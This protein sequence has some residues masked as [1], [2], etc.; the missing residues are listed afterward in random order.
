MVKGLDGLLRHLVDE[1]ALCGV[2]GKTC[3]LLLILRSAW[4]RFSQFRWSLSTS[5]I[6]KD[7]SWEL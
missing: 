1:I 4:S 3:L 7:L 6:C 2:E 5:L